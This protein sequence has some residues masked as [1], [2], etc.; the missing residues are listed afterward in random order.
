MPKKDR[1]APFSAIRY[2]SGEEW[3]EGELANSCQNR[4]R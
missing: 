2:R 4:E 3:I 1:R